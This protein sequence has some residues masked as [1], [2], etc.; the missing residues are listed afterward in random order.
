MAS[1]LGHIS[2]VAQLVNEYDIMPDVTDNQGNSAIMYAAVS[3]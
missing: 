3:T 1:Y 2:N